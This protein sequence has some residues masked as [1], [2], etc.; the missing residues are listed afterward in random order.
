MSTLR[1]ELI[2]NNSNLFKIMVTSAANLISRC[3]NVTDTT[4]SLTRCP[5]AAITYN[6][7]ETVNPGLV[8]SVSV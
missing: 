5:N 1:F 8:W 4:S 6:L 7:V 2:I 3:P